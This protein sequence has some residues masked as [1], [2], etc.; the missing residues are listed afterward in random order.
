MSDG[1]VVAV[2][3]ALEQAG[4]AHMVVGSL[5]SNLYGVP[6]STLDADIVVQLDAEAIDRLVAHL[7]PDIC[8]DKQPTF[9]TATGRTCY[10]LHVGR[11]KFEIELFVLSDDPHNQ[12][13]FSRRR[14][15]LIEG[16]KPYAPTPEDVIIQKLRWSRA[17]RRA[18]DIEDVRGVI[19]VQADGLDWTYIH[20]WCDT[21]GTRDLL[22]DVR[23]SIPPP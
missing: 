15:V 22:D 18:K 6:R 11:T 10:H 23:R 7:P 20:R 5:S 3:K 17:G 8:I 19:S 14:H 2:L 9:E 16:H 21:H 1:A 4:I 12:E 13:R